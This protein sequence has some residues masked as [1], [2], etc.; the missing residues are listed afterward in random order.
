MSH[1]FTLP[2]RPHPRTFTHAGKGSPGLKHA[3][4]SLDQPKPN[5]GEL[6]HLSAFSQPKRRDCTHNLDGK[7]DAVDTP[8]QMEKASVPDVC[9]GRVYDAPAT[10]GD[11]GSE[12][13]WT[14]EPPPY[15]PPISPFPTHLQ[16]VQGDEQP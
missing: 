2:I 5:R 4:I 1:H 7:P 11:G 6:K 12:N 8:E 9:P 15:S 16:S 14:T 3:T 13:T 10:G